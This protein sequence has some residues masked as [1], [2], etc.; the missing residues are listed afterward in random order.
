MLNRPEKKRRVRGSRGMFRRVQQNRERMKALSRPEKERRV[1]GSRQREIPRSVRQTAVRMAASIR[2][3]NR[4]ENRLEKV[5]L[6]YR[7]KAKEP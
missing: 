7:R 3:E 1:R 6:I 4:L 2:P 5:V